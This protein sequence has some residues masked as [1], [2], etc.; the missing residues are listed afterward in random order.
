MDKKAE[1]NNS[2]LLQ[3]VDAQS[4]LFNYI[5]FVLGILI[6]IYLFIT[7]WMFFAIVTVI[8]TFVAWKTIKVSELGYI[9]DTENDLYSFP[10]GKAADS[11]GDYFSM[12]WILQRLGLERNK[13]SLSSITH[14]GGEN[15]WERTYNEG[16]KRYQTTHYYTI[17]IEG[18][19]GTITHYMS[20]GKR[21]QLYSMLQQTLNM[22]APVVVY[23]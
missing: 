18:T 19:S 17:T 9:I 15:S 20:Q 10:G 3:I 8:L 12:S 22:G 1:N 7:G 13:I 16:L 6:S 4:V 2:G 21:D 11:V 23:E 14:I 5:L